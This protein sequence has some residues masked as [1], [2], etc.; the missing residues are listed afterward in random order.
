MRKR[1]GLK[2]RSSRG[3]GRY[4]NYRPWV[5]VSEI[6]SR[7][8]T[9]E[10]VDWKH[11][12]TVQCLS[13]GEMMLYHILRWND[14]VDDINESFPLPL[15]DTLEIAE[16]YGYNHPRDITTKE[17]KNMTSDFLVWLKDGSRVVYSLI[18]S[19]K[20]VHTELCTGDNAKKRAVRTQCG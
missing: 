12:R 8:T 6:S 15:E 10:V 11:G 3:S 13:D 19:R 20:T 5:R 14:D 1:V 18:D 2:D 7:G 17:P 16:M 4:E 9:A